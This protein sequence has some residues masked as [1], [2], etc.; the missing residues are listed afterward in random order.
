MHDPRS[1]AR[2]Y[3]VESDVDFKVATLLETTEYHSRT[4]FMAQQAAE[5]MAKAL[6][7]VRGIYS[8]DQNTS[9]LFSAVYG[10]E[11]PEAGQVVQAMTA[12]ERHGARVRFPLFQRPELPIWVPSQS[13]REDDAK[14]AVAMASMV[15]TTLRPVVEKALA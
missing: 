8:T 10:A 4:I 9:S 5:K 12:L 1:I 6:L 7:A 3:L 14:R 13:Y 11:V 2:A 15:V